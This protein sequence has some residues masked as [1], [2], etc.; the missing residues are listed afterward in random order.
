MP[1]EWASSEPSRSWRTYTALHTLSETEPCF[2]YSIDPLGKPMRREVPREGAATAEH[3][4]LY[5]P[6]S[7]YLPESWC[8]S[9]F[10]WPSG[11][12]LLCWTS[13]AITRCREIM[14]PQLSIVK[15]RF[16]KASLRPR[17][18]RHR[19]WG[20]TC[21]LPNRRTGTLSYPIEEQGHS[22]SRRLLWSS[23][24]LIVASSESLLPAFWACTKV[25]V[26]LP[27]TSNAVRSFMSSIHPIQLSMLDNAEL[28]VD[29]LRRLI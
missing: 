16:A 23:S 18:A 24:F 27:P 1:T 8:S 9:F 13:C 6:S 17:C 26:T 7:F 11:V 5:E 10:N 19:S 25:C 29:F 14:T 3:A 12:V 22:P 20:A 2:G 28:Q 4:C 15:T 21:M